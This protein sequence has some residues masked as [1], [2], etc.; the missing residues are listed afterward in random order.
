MQLSVDATLPV[1]FGG[2]GGQTLYIDTEGS[3]FVDRVRYIAIATVRHCQ[4]I[5]QANEEQ[6]TW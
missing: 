1:C 5:A 6:G 4:H 2:L 3:F